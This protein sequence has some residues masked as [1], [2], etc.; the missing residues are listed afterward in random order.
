MLIKCI[1]VKLFKIKKK[2]SLTLKMK[3]II[4]FVQS[5]F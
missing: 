3:K 2:T 1:K 4:D 5:E